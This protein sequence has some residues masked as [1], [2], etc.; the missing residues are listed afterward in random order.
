MKVSTMSFGV[1]YGKNG[2]VTLPILQLSVQDAVSTFNG[3]ICRLKTF[4]ELKTDSGIC[5]E[6]LKDEYSIRGE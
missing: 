5:L 1:R 4:Q 3:N 2:F 6:V